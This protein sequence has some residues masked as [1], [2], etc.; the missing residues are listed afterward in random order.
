[1]DR[2]S[3]APL[4]PDTFYSCSSWV[5]MNSVMKH[6]TGSTD[7]T[8]SKLPQVYLFQFINQHILYIWYM[9]NIWQTIH[10]SNG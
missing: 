2:H 9:Y 5:A 3:Q 4:W 6:H 10:R 8:G 1:M 7:C